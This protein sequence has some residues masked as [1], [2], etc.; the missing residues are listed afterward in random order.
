[1]SQVRTT[2]ELREAM[3]EITNDK[4]KSEPCSFFI[5]D[6]APSDDSPWAKYLIEYEE[7][8]SAESDQELPH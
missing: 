7:I 4:S 1:M 5:F 3:D 6:G 8:K 2:A